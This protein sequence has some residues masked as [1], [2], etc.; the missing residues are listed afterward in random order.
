[1]MLE[2]DVSIVILDDSN[3]DDQN[4]DNNDDGDLYYDD[5]DMI[6]MTLIWNDNKLLQ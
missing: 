2:I 6:M 1:M 4:N 3:D 5:I